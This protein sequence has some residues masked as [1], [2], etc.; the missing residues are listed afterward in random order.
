MKDQRAILEDKI[1]YL[2]KKIDQVSDIKSNQ[3]ME[4]LLDEIDTL[5]TKLLEIETQE[6]YNQLNN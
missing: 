2:Y 4:Y 1:E 6:Y 5:K 3:Q